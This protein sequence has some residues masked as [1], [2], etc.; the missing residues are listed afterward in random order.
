[1]AKIIEQW[2]PI[3]GWVGL[4]QVSNFGRIRSLRW[5][6]P[7]V[8]KPGINQNGYHFVILQNQGRKK[9]HVVSRLVAH[10]FIP[11]TDGKP[12]VNHKDSDKDNNRA[13]N[14]EWMTNVENQHHSV[15]HEMCNLKLTHS[16]VLEIKL[17]KGQA[18]QQAIADR[19]GVSRSMIS[20]IHT[21][22]R[23]TVLNTG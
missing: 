14:L 8:L 19:Y 12:E 4:Y 6:N 20:H 17:M 2:R 18:T 5:A 21:G 16:Q 13:T 9:T 15:I 3:N 1:M 22:F 23:R 10:A 11:N 7:L